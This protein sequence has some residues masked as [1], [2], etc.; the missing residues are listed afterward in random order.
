MVNFNALHYITL[1][2]SENNFKW[3]QIADVV[4]PLPAPGGTM[5]LWLGFQTLPVCVC[6]QLPRVV[7]GDPSH[8]LTEG[9]RSGNTLT[10][11]SCP[12]LR[13]MDPLSLW[14]S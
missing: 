5:G 7:C 1:T 9:V 4:S 8:T 11:S 10:L 3:T 12:K 2:C 13:S 6:C 14:V